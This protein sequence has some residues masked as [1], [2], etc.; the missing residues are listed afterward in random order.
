M[1][2]VMSLKNKILVNLQWMLLA[3]FSCQAISWVSTLL[4]MRILHPDD[5]GLIAMAAVLVNLMAM[6]NEMGIGQAIVQAD[7][8]T[9]NKIRQCYGIV[10]L[11]NLFSYILL[12]LLSPVMV[13]FFG[14]EKLSLVIPVIGL[15]F[16]MQIFLVIP[17]AL[18]DKKLIFRER[19]IYEVGASVTG[20]L[21]TLLMAY[22][23]LGVWSI[24]IGNLWVVAFCAIL[25]NYKFPF[26]HLPSFKFVDIG[27]IAK[28]GLMAVLGRILWFFYSQA[29]TLLVGRFLG[30]AALGFY[31]VG[32]QIATLPLVK[33]SGIFSQLAMAGFS[34]IKNDVQRIRDS[35]ILVARV[36][37]F[38]SVPIFWGISAVSSDFVGVVLGEAWNQAIFPLQCI[39]IMLPFR[40]LSIAIS[41]AV[42]AVGRPELNVVNLFVACVVMPLAFVVAM[43]YWGLAGVCYAWLVIYPLWFIYVLFQCL[44]LFDIKVGEY[45]RNIAPSFIFGALMFL[46]VVGARSFVP[47]DGFQK[48]VLLVFIGAGTYVALFLIFAKNYSSQVI[49]A[50]RKD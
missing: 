38:F 17:N 48:L 33:I 1:S 42:N 39:A 14:E 27:D 5:Y 3:K 22:C 12:C 8:L 24:I 9:E 49:C 43:H 23:G 16:L 7:N 50:V 30:K 18:L 32:V 19:A 26:R 46:I 11:I 2:V 41:Q 15:Q 13:W 21:L 36:S 45:F 4:V 20:T 40:V 35:V 34:R 25:I 31:S 47:F 10:I 28:F 29:D 6:V 44:P 37:S